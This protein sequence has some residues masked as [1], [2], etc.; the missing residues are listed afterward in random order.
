M[1]NAL[2][3]RDIDKLVYSFIILTISSKAF[4][5]LSERLA[6][7]SM[8]L[9]DTE[10]AD[11]KHIQVIVRDITEQKQAEKDKRNAQYKASKL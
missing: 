8:K 5:M 6:E 2:G 9:I 11:Q 4:S 10:D 7:V 3:G 1:A